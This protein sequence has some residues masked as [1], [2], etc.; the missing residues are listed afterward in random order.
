MS[1]FLTMILQTT[2]AVDTISQFFLKFFGGI[3]WLVVTFMSMIPIIELK[4]GILWGTSKGGMNGFGA[5]SFGLLGCLIVSI[6][7][8]FALKPLLDWLKRTRLFKR[9]IGRIEKSFTKKAQQLED[10]S[11][12]TEKTT[13][14]KR[15]I[16]FM[17]LLTL[18]I[19]I[20]IPL[21]GVW[22]GCAIGIFI[23]LKRWQVLVSSIVG[24][25]ISATLLVL[26]SN[27]FG[28]WT[29]ILFYIM[30]GLAG[31]LFLVMVVKIT[32]DIVKERKADKFANIPPKEDGER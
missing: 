6:I 25:I 18:F 20:P 32:I 28:Q 13:S 30:L 31:V 8:V 22:T 14:L 27:L 10:V 5:A 1:T 26:I 11:G 4:G 23:G 2:E 7:L 24:C 17:T 29:D 12:V 3:N 16:I 19:A 9:I 15:T 21:S